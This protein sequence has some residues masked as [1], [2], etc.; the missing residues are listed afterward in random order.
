MEFISEAESSGE[1]KT[2]RYFY[3]CPACGTKILDSQLTILRGQEKILIR[4]QT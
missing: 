1:K 4:I 2:I 3:R